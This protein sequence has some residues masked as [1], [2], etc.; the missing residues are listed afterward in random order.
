MSNFTI[1]EPRATPEGAVR[2][3][4]VQNEE[5]KI[6]WQGIVALA[7]PA[8][9]TTTV[10][11]W[12]RPAAGAAWSWVASGARGV[13]CDFLCK[14]LKTSDLRIIDLENLLERRPHG[15][16]HLEVTTARKGVFDGGYLKNFGEWGALAKEVGVPGWELL[17]IMK[18]MME[19]GGLDFDVQGKF[20]RFMD[21]IP[22]VPALPS[23]NAAQL[24]YL[25]R[26]SA[27]MSV[28]QFA[29][30]LQVSAQDVLAWE[31]PD[32]SAGE[33]APKGPVARLLQVLGKHSVVTLT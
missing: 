8:R 20:A 32:N 5:S 6:D 22:G 11:I 4:S 25:R 21:A 3:F 23:L 7:S 1:S 12:V 26:F 19:Q 15:S 14:Q 29:D 24:Q 17:A 30:W 27:Q 2:T 31:S 10:L 28:E 18:S 16:L 9:P 33:R 13:A